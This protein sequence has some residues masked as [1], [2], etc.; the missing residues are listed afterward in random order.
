MIEKQ[1]ISKNIREYLVQKYIESSL[2]KGS[3]SSINLKKT[4]LGERII[5]HTSRP[6]L[7]VGRKGENI[8]KLTETLKHDFHMEN[9]QIEVAEITEQYLDP[10]YVSD[11]IVLLFDRFGPKRFKSIGYKSLQNIMDAGA[12]GAEIVISG[13]GVPSSR[14]KSWRF[15]AGHLKKSGYISENEVRRAITVANLRS[16]SVGIKVSILTPDV[17]LPD[18]IKIKDKKI[19][20]E[21]VKEV[22]VEE[23]KETETIKEKVKKERKPRKK[24]EKVENEVKDRTETNE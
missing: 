24:K 23:T 3:F 18:L 9:P 8:V 5:I 14:A 13:R 21:E 11:H 7:I 15:S 16:G 12:L 1:I 2:P 17:I 20:V 6:G 10:I 4:P 19:I 22:V